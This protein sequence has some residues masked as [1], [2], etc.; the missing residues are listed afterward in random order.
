MK[1]IQETKHTLAAATSCIRMQNKD[2]RRKEERRGQ[3]WIEL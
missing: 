1:L 3:V 2:S